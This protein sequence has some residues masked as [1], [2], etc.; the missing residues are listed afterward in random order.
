MKPNNSNKFSTADFNQKINN[1]IYFDNNATTATDSEIIEEISPLFKIPLNNSSIHQMGQNAQMLCEEA[2]INIKSALNANNYEV[3]FTSGAS[4]A[5][6]TIINGFLNNHNSQVETAFYSAIEHDSVYN[7]R[8]SNKDIVEIRVLES[9]ELDIENFETEIHQFKKLSPNKI[10]LASIMLANSET[11]AIQDIKKI[12]K[13]VHS[14][15]GIIHCDISQG[16]AKINID[17]EDLNIDFATISGHKFYAPQGSGAI[18]MRKGLD[19]KPLIYGGGQE[20]FKRAGTVNIASIYGLGLACKYCKK[21]L[22]KMPLINKYRDYLEEEMLKTA[23]EKIKIFSKNTKR[24]GN[25]SY[26]S[27]KNSNNQSEIINFDLNKIMVS[28]GSACS[29][30]TLHQSRVL[31]AMQIKADFINGAIRISLGI[32]NNAEEIDKFIEIWKKS[33]LK[34]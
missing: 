3:I 26:Y 29:S 22:A 14:Y 27:I 5:N 34:Y 4:E 12:A 16:I 20:K 13:I 21:Y 25:T 11:G 32:N 2:R 17:L 19:F 30:G 15:Q 6:N 1:L 33:L 8:P 10:F 23:S 9:G 18:L 28:G 7:V 24:L 31:R